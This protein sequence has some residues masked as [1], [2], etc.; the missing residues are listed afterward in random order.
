MKWTL[1]GQKT[2]KFYQTDDNSLVTSINFQDVH[3]T[4]YGTTITKWIKE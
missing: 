3:W 4:G 1:I 2:G